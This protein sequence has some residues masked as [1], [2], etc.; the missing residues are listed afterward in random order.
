VRFVQARFPAIS[1]QGDMLI[2]AFSVEQ[3]LAGR[4]S[5][6]AIRRQLAQIMH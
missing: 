5:S 1:M 6:F 3:G 4:P 2:V